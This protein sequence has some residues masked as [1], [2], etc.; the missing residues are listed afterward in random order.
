MKKTI[1]NSKNQSGQA[2]LEYILLLSILVLGASALSKGLAVAWEQGILS[3]G[4]TLERSIK[5]GR[6]P[7]SAWKE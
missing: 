5:T 2:V 7:F 1:R 6:A 3:F 4:K